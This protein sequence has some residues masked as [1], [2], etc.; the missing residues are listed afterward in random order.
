LQSVH[1]FL[2]PATGRING[3]SQSVGTDYSIRGGRQNQTNIVNFVL[4]INSDI[5]WAN[6]QASFIFTSRSDLL[7]GSFLPDTQSLFVSG[8]ETLSVEH[9]LANW[10]P[11]SGTVN[12]ALLISGL[13]TADN[14][15]NVNINQVSFNS[16]T[17]VFTV[18][19]N[20]NANPSLEMIYL[21]YVIVLVNAPFTFVQYNPLVG[22][23]AATYAFEG[24]DAIAANSITYEGYALNFTASTPSTAV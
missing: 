15:F 2:T 11:V 9:Q 13:R 3:Y 24:I 12:F 23:P 7:V 5:S 1:I 19:V 10:S 17:G 21:T 14:F 4:L 8:A 18:E 20:T 16:Q 22:G 6:I